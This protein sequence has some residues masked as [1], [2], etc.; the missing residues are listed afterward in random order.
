MPA[1]QRQFKLECTHR[2]RTHARVALVSIVTYRVAN[3]NEA[4]WKSYSIGIAT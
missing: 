2:V 3:D 1:S 4:R